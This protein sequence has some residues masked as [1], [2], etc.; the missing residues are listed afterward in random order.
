MHIIIHVCVCVCV[1]VCDYLLYTVSE[2]CMVCVWGLR[3]HMILCPC[4]IESMAWNICDGQ[5]IILILF[6]CLCSAFP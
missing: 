3:Y 4:G 2:A 1:C 6:M 5:G